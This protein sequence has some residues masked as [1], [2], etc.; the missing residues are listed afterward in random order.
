MHQ[1]GSLLLFDWSFWKGP[2]RTPDLDET[3]KPFVLL[4]WPRKVGGGEKE[5][6]RKKSCYRLSM[7]SYRTLQSPECLWKLRP[8]VVC[9]A[10][11]IQTGPWMLGEAAAAH[12]AQRRAPSVAAEPLQYE[13]LAEALPTGNVS[14]PAMWNRFWLNG[15][16]AQ[17]QCLETQLSVLCFFLLACAVK[18]TLTHIF[19]LHTTVTE[20]TELKTTVFFDS[21]SSSRLFLLPQKYDSSGGPWW[22]AGWYATILP[23][24][25]FRGNSVRCAE[26]PGHRGHK[27][28]CLWGDS[29]NPDAYF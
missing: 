29:K 2:Q 22:S 9:M 21:P 28:E 11:R 13:P 25:I 18:K 10:W 6:Q 19:N 14:S 24:I 16:T 1:L 17:S 8:I 15:A 27:E 26:A 20:C 7:W 4:I 5:K 23:Q 12:G 3:N